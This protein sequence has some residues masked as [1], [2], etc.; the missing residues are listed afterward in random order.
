MTG[1]KS[2]P[3]ERKKQISSEKMKTLPKTAIFDQKNHGS[4]TFTDNRIVFWYK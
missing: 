2:K 1:E 4:S 3:V